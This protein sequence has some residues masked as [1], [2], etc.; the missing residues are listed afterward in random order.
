MRVLVTRPRADAEAVAATLAA[1]GVE[2]MVEPML[3]IVPLPAGDFDLDGVQAVLLTSANGARA[4]AG[5]TDRRD[6][7]LLA[8]GAATA[9]A[10]R[11]AGFARIAAAGGDVAA[12]AARAK[13]CLDPAAGPLVHV[14]A[15]A[16]AGDLAGRLAADGFAVRRAVLY[17][18]RPAVALSGP[19]V[20]ALAGGAIDA[21]LLFSPR[22]AKSFV[23]LAKK[24]AVAAALERLRALCL[25][26]AVARDAGAATWREIA[27]AARPDQEAL[28][29]LI[30][31]APH[32]T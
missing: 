3:D 17:E 31:S 1:R 20:A 22:T 6:L 28:L 25:S 26:A 5:A 24:A 7:A 8:V 27:V 13:A 23:R 11:R 19:A 21:V 2:A 10:A 14:S 29:A 16:I 32:G 15:S 9:E 4:L 12:L 30:D 18:A